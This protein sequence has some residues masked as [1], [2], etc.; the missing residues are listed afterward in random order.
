M[1]KRLLSTMLVLAVLA[2]SVPVPAFGPESPK[3]AAATCCGAMT[4]CEVG[5]PCSGGG[6]ACASTAASKGD[7]AGPVLASA[8][9]HGSA[10]VVTGASVDPTLGPGIA[11]S[12]EIPEAA[13]DVATLHRHLTLRAAKPAVPPPRA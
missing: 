7:S 9:C 2:G 8:P 13:G 4:C 5:L 3:P 1:M 6:M 11:H 10:A 12:I